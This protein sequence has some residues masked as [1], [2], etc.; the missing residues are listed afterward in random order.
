MS[1]NPNMP[2]NLRRPPMRPNPNMMRNR[3]QGGPPRPP[4]GPRPNYNQN[5]NQNNNNQNNNANNNNFNN[6]QQQQQQ[7]PSAQDMFAN[8]TQAYNNM[9]N[10]LQFMNAVGIVNGIYQ[11]AT[12]M[13]NKFAS[14]FMHP[15][16]MQQFAQQNANMNANNFYQNLNNENEK[17]KFFDEF[18]SY[19]TNRMANENNVVKSEPVQ[20]KPVK[21]EVVQEEVK[22]TRYA[23]LESQKENLSLADYLNKECD[24]SEFSKFTP[25][26]LEPINFEE[27]KCDMEVDS[28]LNAIDGGVLDVQ[29][30]DEDELHDILE[31]LDKKNEDVANDIE[32]NEYSIEESEDAI[33]E[34]M[35]QLQKE[36]QEL[37]E[38]YQENFE[39][40]AEDNQEE[41]LFLNEES[42]DNFEEEQ[43][44]EDL[45]YLFED[46]E[47]D[48]EFL[49]D[50]EP[51]EVLFDDED[52]VEE[53][54][55][56][57]IQTENDEVDYSNL[58]ISDSYADQEETA[59]EELNED[60]DEEVEEEKVEDYSDIIVD[61][62]GEGLINH[63]MTSKVLNAEDD[64]KEIYND[65][66]NYLLSYKG[67]KSR[68]SSACES[69]RLSRKLMAKF[70][71]IGRTVKLYL[72]LD[73]D[74][75]PSNIYHQKNESKK[76]AY[77]DV[78]FMVKIK[79]SLSRRKAKEL[80][81]KMMAEN[82]LVKNFKYKEKDY[83]EELRL[84]SEEE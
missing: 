24:E 2:N 39:E 45:D 64:V 22:E 29:E 1:N 71:I 35:L 14:P 81:D 28:P 66:K 21:E 38:L 67:I 7:G 13:Q 23:V 42:D 79:S 34:E 30:Y 69:F 82:D 68:Y 10:N 63:N 54:Q 19:L 36:L 61:E 52:L 12:N 3:P 44:D 31:R 6:Q 60:L 17:Q 46:S 4:F 84:S 26:D 41:L 53:N 72:A 73:P 47:N 83:V 20:E 74:E 18:Y 59:K 75:Y 48:N 70:V 56:E 43:I 50:E 62:S 78:P 15:D 8:L 55:E 11:N 27:P 80:I 49:V 58:T 5:I 9:V 16:Q 32:E 77:V 51:E 33:D 65:I 25:V 37:E 40:E 76:K 57:E